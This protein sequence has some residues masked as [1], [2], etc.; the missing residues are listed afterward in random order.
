M[1]PV[2]PS[3]HR[4]SS[5]QQWSRMCFV[6]SG[7]QLGFRKVACSCSASWKIKLSITHHNTTQD[8]S[9][10]VTKERC[11]YTDHISN[12]AV[13][14]CTVLICKALPAI[15]FGPEAASGGINTGLS[16]IGTVTS[17]IF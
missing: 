16:P 3:I 15:K 9:T 13:G 10:S 6:T 12:I 1:K 17:H 8:S 2:R 4:T 14:T 5:Q 11:G 7:C